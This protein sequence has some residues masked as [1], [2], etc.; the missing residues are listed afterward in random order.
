MWKDTTQLCAASLGRMAK[1]RPSCSAFP[2]AAQLICSAAAAAAANDVVVD[3]DDDYS[4]T[5]N[6]T[7]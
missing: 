5:D 3:D 6:R 2:L 1:G 7:N 4:F